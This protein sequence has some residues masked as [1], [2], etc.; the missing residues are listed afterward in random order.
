MTI[1]DVLLLSESRHTMIRS[2]S[3]SLDKHRLFAVC[4]SL[5]E[6]LLASFVACFL[7]FKLTSRFL[8]LKFKNAQ[9]KQKSVGYLIRGKLFSKSSSS[10]FNSSQFDRVPDALATFTDDAMSSIRFISCSFNSSAID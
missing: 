4:S 3:N 9:T 8:K 1:F 2:L 7:E 5:E 6:V 10:F